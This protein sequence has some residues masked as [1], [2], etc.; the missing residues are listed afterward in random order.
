MATVYQRKDP[1]GYDRAGWYIYFRW[2]GK[3]YREFAGDAVTKQD[4]EQY[5]A[6]RMREVQREEIYDK[7]PE[8]VSFAAF[9]E[10][11][12]KT[13]SP[14]KK[15][16]D[17]DRSMLATFKVHWKGL[18]LDAITPKMVEEFK[19]KRLRYRA[20]ATVNK[21]LQ[22]VKRLFK[23]AVEWGKIRTSPAATVKKERAN[24]QRVR[25]LE[26]DELRRLFSHLPDYLHRI[27]A[28]ARF[29]G[30]RLGE[31]LGLRWSDVDFKRGILTFRDTKNGEDGTVKMNETTRA[32]LESLPAP[33]NRSQRVFPHVGKM[34]LYRDWRRACRKARIGVQCGCVGQPR[35]PKSR[36]K[37]RTCRDTGIIPD[38]RFHDL[39]HQAATDLLTRG[40][41]LND[42]RDFLRH[43]TSAMTLRYAHLV[44][45]RREQTARLLDALAGPETASPEAA[46]E[47]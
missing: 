4:A 29:T 23:K 7:K 37:C 40:A 14:R 12:L 47:R 39:R 15:S 18:N 20:V 11:F 31:I 22:V 16:K 3:R 46:T 33:M 35:D 17:R 43:K 10:D 6:K 5:L 8:A 32:L 2:R 21:E 19:A 1:D 30:A 45:D 42:V 27:A 24:N 25:F 26:P 34:K 41:N 13:D 28:F 36:K 38:F 44:E 9:A